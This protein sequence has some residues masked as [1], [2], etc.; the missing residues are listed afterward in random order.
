MVAPHLAAPGA[1]RIA[2]AAH[3]LHPFCHLVEHHLGRAAVDRCARRAAGQRAF[4]AVQS[5]QRHQE[6]AGTDRVTGGAVHRL[7]PG[8]ARLRANSPERGSTRLCSMLIRPG[9]VLLDAGHTR[10]GMI[11]APVSKAIGAARGRPASGTGDTRRARFRRGDGPR[12][13]HSRPA[14]G[15]THE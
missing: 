13:P 15:N 7:D 9:S 11:V 4:G 1:A 6:L 8:C 5:L 10:T 14:R 12:T 2:Q 3:P